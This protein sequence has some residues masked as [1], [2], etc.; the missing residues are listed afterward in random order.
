MLGFP[1]FVNMLFCILVLL[2]YLWSF[3]KRKKPNYIMIALTFIFMGVMIALDIVFH[4]N[5]AKAADNLSSA[6]R[7]AL[8]FIDKSLTLAIV[9]VVFVGISAVLLATLPLYKKLIMK[10]NTRKVVEST[11]IKEEIDTSEEV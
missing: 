9:H 3:P 10:I 6:E 7:A 2:L 1:V 5:L 11:E 4:I 8:P